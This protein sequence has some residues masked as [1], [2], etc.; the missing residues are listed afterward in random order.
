M[1]KKTNAS[2]MATVATVAAVGTAA[3]LMAKP[4]KSKKN[5]ADLKKSAST[6]IKNAGVIVDTISQMLS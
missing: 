1:N 4:K 2:T 5:N 6:A 3:Y